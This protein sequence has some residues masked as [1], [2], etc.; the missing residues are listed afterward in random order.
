MTTA[1]RLPSLNYLLQHLD[2]D[3]LE[4]ATLIESQNFSRETLVIARAFH[5]SVGNPYRLGRAFDKLC[6]LNSLPKA[7]NKSPV[8]TE[9]AILLYEANLEKCHRANQVLGGVTVAVLNAIIDGVHHYYFVLKHTPVY[10]K[11][12]MWDRSAKLT[13][14]RHCEKELEKIRKKYVSI[15]LNNLVP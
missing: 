2:A 11:D 13:Q 14:I 3:W 12:G 6:L 5:I 15:Y 8:L 10:K 9:L 7:V 4:M 1:E